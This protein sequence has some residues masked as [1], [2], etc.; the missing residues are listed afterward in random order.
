MWKRNFC[1]M[2]IYFGLKM[3]TAAGF[4]LHFSFLIL[5]TAFENKDIGLFK[6]VVE[7][8]I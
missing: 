3:N 7:I 6:S 1:S 8:L 2:I 4:F 5:T